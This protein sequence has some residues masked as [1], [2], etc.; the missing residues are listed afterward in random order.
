MKSNP[1]MRARC[2]AVALL[3]LT[4]PACDSDDAIVDVFNTPPELE[5]QT[6]TTAKNTALEVTLSGEDAEGDALSFQIASA[7]GNGT[8]GAF[9][10]LSARSVRL[11]YTPDEDF[12]GTDSF[13]YTANDGTDDSDPATVTVTVENAVPV[14][15]AVTV[16][17]AKGTA[18]TITLQGTDADDGESLSFAIA[19]PPENG[20]LGQITASSS[21]APTAATA[22]ETTAS[23]TVEYTPDAGFGGPDT[24]TY[25]VSDGTDSSEP[26]TVTIEIENEAPVAQPRTATTTGGTTVDIT[27]TGSD[28][29]GDALSFAVATQP[30]NGTLGEFGNE[31]AT[32]ATIAYTP[33]AGFIGTDTFTF[34]VSDGTDTSAPATVTVTVS[35][36]APA[37]DD[38]SAGTTKNVAVT[39]TLTGS[40]PDGDALTFAINSNP[41]NG[42]LGAITSTGDDSAEVTY[43]PDSGFVG[44]DAFTFTASD[45]TTTSDPATVT[46]TV[47]NQAPTGDAQT[48]EMDTATETEKE[49]TLMGSDPDGDPLTFAIDTGP[50]NGS[51]SSITNP[52]ATS[53][54]VTYTPDSG[55]TG[56]DTFT[57]TVSDGSATSDP[58]TVT[59]NVN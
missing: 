38:G 54:D 25:T 53:A 42:S 45:G 16:T 7:P 27:V 29:D 8:L 35:N 19:S 33:D 57:F 48:V 28:P 51:L 24:F 17:T 49:I 9:T 55:F 50:A 23:V 26:A 39:I 58:V 36:S 5:D 47:S 30:E 31:T 15:Q 40:D 1:R 43:T 18:V 32:S 2:A 46:V 11:V 41:L 44:S 21:S 52:T 10:E 20:T 3:T 13:T 6:V 34:T 4:L 14:A 22:L 56:Q 37:A 12:S 59:V